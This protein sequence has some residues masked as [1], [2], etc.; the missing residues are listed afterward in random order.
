MFNRFRAVIA[1]A[2]VTVLA[3]GAA[4]AWAGPLLTGGAASARHGAGA[5]KRPHKHK[6]CATAAR[7]HRRKAARKRRHAHC[8]HHRCGLHPAGRRL[9]AR[10]PL[11]RRHSV[12]G[13]PG[14]KAPVG[15]LAPSQG[16]ASSAGGGSAFPGVGSGGSSSGASGGSTGSGGGAGSGGST[17]SGG[18]SGGGA[19]EEGQSGGATTG[20][21]AKPSACGYPDAT[22]S[23][24]PAGA[25]LTASGAQTITTNGAV[26]RDVHYTGT[27]TIRADNVTVEDSQFTF[28]DGE[29]DSFGI[30][31]REGYTGTKVIHTTFEGVNCSTTG[32]LFAGVR[33]LSDDSLVMNYD[34]GQCVDDILHGSG[35]L[36]NSYSIDNASIPGDHYEPVSYDGG[37]GGLW[38]EHDTLLNPHGQTAAIFTQCTWGE[39]ATP[40]VVED[41][42]LAGGDY[43]IYGPLS[44][45]CPD[46]GAQETYRNNRFSR[47]YFPKG[48]YYG[49][50]SYINKS[51]A[52]WSGNCWDETLK[53]VGE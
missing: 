20:C 17:G 7:R 41:N 6:L 34:Y 37:Q 47:V 21:M 5:G 51:T 25:P 2:A 16:G 23:G 35:H 19:K 15:A 10:K 4:V 3:S 12:G 8:R 33:N 9:C 11:P 24:V 52:I 28:G 49:V 31:V 18:G 43:V 1:V 38:V 13:V 14:T 32:S 26:V 40:I 45:N 53:E 42:L 36:M 27:L 50:D 39:N 29:E 22:N 48:G 30:D 44:G 46:G